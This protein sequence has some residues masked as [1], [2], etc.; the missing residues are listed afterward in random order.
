MRTFNCEF[1]IYL[2]F[3][4][5]YLCD[6]IADIVAGQLCMPFCFL[7]DDSNDPV[8]NSFVKIVFP[9]YYAKVFVQRTY[10]YC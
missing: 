2:P 7:R 3:I 5:L 1:C 10:S 4:G 8:S 6:E 9:A